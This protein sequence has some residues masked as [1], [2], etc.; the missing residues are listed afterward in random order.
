MTWEFA[1]VSS[2]LVKNASQIVD[3]LRPLTLDDYSRAIDFYA[4]GM[5]RQ[6]G[7]CYIGQFGSLNTPGVSDIDILV[8]TEDDTYK[9][10]CRESLRLMHAAPN[11][12]YLFVHPPSVVPAS[13]VLE[14]NVIHTLENLTTLWGTPPIKE[15][16]SDYVHKLASVNAIVWNSAF[17]RY[18]FHHRQYVHGLRKLLLMLGNVVQSISANYRILGHQT[19]IPRVTSW[20]KE[21]ARSAILSATSNKRHELMRNYL[22]EGLARWL[23]SDWELEAWWGANV[24]ASTASLP[25]VLRVSLDHVTKLKFDHDKAN[26]LYLSKRRLGIAKAWESI[27]PGLG[28]SKPLALDMLRVLKWQFKSV[29]E[30]TVPLFYF[31][32]LLALRSAYEPH[33]SLFIGH[34]CADHSEDRIKGDDWRLALNRYKRAVSAIRDYSTELD[35]PDYSLYGERLMTPFGL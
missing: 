29:V 33:A 6:P 13:L 26:G 14:F 18:T 16:E 23:Q 22:V 10:A 27:R 25:L 34:E 12:P 17:M 28:K 21:Q 7:I 32:V 24:R 19:E 11:G 1:A 20:G 9:S 3:D 31:D 5:A 2:E 15:T 4:Q 30:V 35:E 8:I